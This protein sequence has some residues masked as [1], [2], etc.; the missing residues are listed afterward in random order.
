MEGDV[1]TDA[2]EGDA[3]GLRLAREG[4]RRVGELE[5]GLGERVGAHVALERRR[6]IIGRIE[7]GLIGMGEIVD[8]RF[9]TRGGRAVMRPDRC[10]VMRLVEG[11]DPGAIGLAADD[12]LEL[13]A[14][15]DLAQFV[16]DGSIV[17]AAGGDD[18]L[19]RLGGGRRRLLHRLRLRRRLG[20]AGRIGLGLALGLGLGFGLRLAL[21]RRGGVG[22]GGVRRG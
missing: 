3:A 6:R 18:R 9:G 13:L 4:Q 17:R 15:D 14:A 7:A 22:L 10:E 21:R 8:R 11:F 16:G 5:L 12:S 1:V 19:R 20:R 2:G